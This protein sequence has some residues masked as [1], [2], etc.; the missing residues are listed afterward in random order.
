MNSGIAEIKIRFSLFF[1][2]VKFKD[3]FDSDRAG[4]TVSKIVEICWWK[5]QLHAEQR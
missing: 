3:V 2:L 5:I 4:L 1:T